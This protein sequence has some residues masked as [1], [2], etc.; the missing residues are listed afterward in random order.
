MRVSQQK[1]IQ[2]L[3]LGGMLLTMLL[4]LSARNGEGLRGGLVLLWLLPPVLLLL[5]R[6]ERVKSG[7]SGLCSQQ[8]ADR[9]PIW[10]DFRLW[11]WRL[12]LRL[13]LRFRKTGQPDGRP[14]PLRRWQ[15]A[16]AFL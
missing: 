6:R 2:T 11:L 7:V 12:R 10:P 13:W 8:Y 15:H 16:R 3:L 9:F 1:P 4:S 14:G 5:R